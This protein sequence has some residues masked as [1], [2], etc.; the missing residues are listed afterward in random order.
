M[1]QWRKSL[2][3]ATWSTSCSAQLRSTATY[4]HLSWN[5]K[6]SGVPVLTCLSSVC[7]VLPVKEPLVLLS[8]LGGCLSA[9]LPASCV[10]L[11]GPCPAHISW[12]GAPEDQNHW[13]ERS[14]PSPMPSSIALCVRGF[15]V[16]VKVCLCLLHDLWNLILLC[17]PFQGRVKQVCW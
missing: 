11:L 15:F 3:V 1:P 14:T 2:A 12:T 17:L 9:G 5:G 8:T 13:G 4:I 6:L 10:I 16:N 7:P